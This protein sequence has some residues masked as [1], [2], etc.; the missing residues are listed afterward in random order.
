M[1]R[2]EIETKYANCGDTIKTKDVDAG[3]TP[4]MKSCVKCGAM[5]HSTFY[6]DIR[7][8]LQPTLEWHR[9]TLK[10]LLKWNRIRG[11]EWHIDHVLSGG[12][13]DRKIV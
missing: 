7:P 10:K 2:K 8:D 5:A 6:K 1:T 3:V 12:L 13:V 11:M 4:A 9:P